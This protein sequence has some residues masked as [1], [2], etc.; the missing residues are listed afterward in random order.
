[1]LNV[2]SEAALT[3]RDELEKEVDRDIELFSRVFLV[4][5]DG[6][7]IPAERA[8]IKTYLAWKLGI[9]AAAE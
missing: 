1:M 5:G 7:L 8:I 2:T 4:I 9:V 6:G 3:Q